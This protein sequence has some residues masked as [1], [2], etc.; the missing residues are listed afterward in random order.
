MISAQIKRA[1][2]FIAIFLGT[3][4]FIDQTVVLAQD[5]PNIDWSYPSKIPQYHKNSRAPVLVADNTGLIHGLTVDTGDGLVIVHRTWSKDV[6]WTIPVDVVLPPRA[7]TAEI[8]GAQVDNNDILHLIVFYGIAQD[9]NIYHTSVPIALASSGAEWAPLRLVVND[10]GPIPHGFFVADGDGKL[11]IVY[12]GYEAGLG[13]YEAYSEDSGETWSNAEV[14]Y[15]APGDLFLPAAVDLHIDDAGDLHAV[16]SI[17]N[18][19]RG[20]G[21]QILY[22][23]KSIETDSW[24]RPRVIAERNEGEYESDWASVTTIN[25]RIIILYQDG[26]PTSKFM[27]FSP[28]DGRYWSEPQ[29]IWPHI[30]EYEN[31]V[32]LKDGDGG[33][34]AILG[35]RLGDCCHGM[36]YSRYEENKWSNLQPL[37]QG[38][39]TLDFDPSAPTAVISRGNLLLASWWMDSADRNGAWYSFGYLPDSAE[40]PTLELTLPEEENVGDETSTEN[41]LDPSLEETNNYIPEDQLT[42][43]TGFSPAVPLTVGII[44]SLIGLLIGFGIWFTLFK[45]R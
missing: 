1:G 17:W 29:K 37:I 11:T 31:A 41:L 7:G 38:P 28:N 45:L 34:H 13:L 42:E 5:T 19:E 6:G 24:S 12:E 18:A 3:L 23:Q 30:G 22:S 26:S 44:T 32:F 40:L 20:V 4:L 25:D 21:E 2:L 9:A 36:W 8:L 35:N 16:W 33:L 43:E 27:R 10:A 39:K 15:L 14:V